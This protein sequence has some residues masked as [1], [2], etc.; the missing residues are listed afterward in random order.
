MKEED[1]RKDYPGKYSVVAQKEGQEGKPA[2]C[3]SITTI[4]RSFRIG[5]MVLIVALLVVVP[6]VV[7]KFKYIY[8][9]L[10]ISTN[11]PL[12]F[13]LANCKLYITEDSTLAADDIY[14]TADVPGKCYVRKIVGRDFDHNE[15]S[16]HEISAHSNIGYTDA[17]VTKMWINP[18]AVLSGLEVACSGTCYI[19]QMGPSLLNLGSGTLAIS[20]DTVEL[21]AV[22]V[23]AGQVQANVLKGNLHIYSLALTKDDGQNHII[24]GEGD[25]VI[26]SLNSVKIAWSNDKDHVCMYAPEMTELGPSKSS[27]QVSRDASSTPSDCSSS[28]FLCKRS[29][30]CSVSTSAPALTL[31]SS[32]G[33]VYAN[34]IDAEGTPVSDS[35]KSVRGW[36]YTRGLEFDDNLNRTLTDYVDGFNGSAK[37]DPLIWVSLGATQSFS[38]AGMVFLLVANTAYLNA[39]PWWISFFSANLLLGNI[40]RIQGNLA[41]GV[42]PFKTLPTTNDLHTIRSLLLTRLTL[43]SGRADAAYA[44]SSSFPPISSVPQSSLGF[45]G[46]EGSTQFYGISFD[47]SQYSL[48][49]YGLAR[50]LSLLLAVIISCILAFIM[51]CL[52]FYILLIVLEKVVA[53]FLQQNSHLRQYTQRIRKEEK[54]R[55]LN[56]RPNH[57]A[58]VNMKDEE[59]G[60]NKSSIIS[61][62]QYML[63]DI[64]VS[65]LKKN[66]T[67]SVDE[68]CDV[69]FAKLNPDDVDDFQPIR[70]KVLR[71]EYEKMCFLKQMSEEDL[72][73]DTNKKKFQA[74][75]FT[76]EK[77][78]KGK[79]GQEVEM[80]LKVRWLRDDE[81]RASP[82][83]INKQSPDASLQKFFRSNCVITTFDADKIEFEEFKE[84]Y[85]KY[86]ADERLPSIVLTRARLHD[87]FSI[88]S[89]TEMPD[90]MVRAET[91]IKYKVDLNQVRQFNEELI[92]MNSAQPKQETLKAI[93][94]NAKSKARQ[95][96]A[97]IYDVIAVGLHL[98]WL[99]ILGC[100][101]VILPL[102]V[103]LEI[104]E[105]SLSDYQYK[106]KYEDFIYA[107]WN[108]P[109][110]LQYLSP[111]SLVCLI[112][113]G[114]YLFM[115]TIELVVYY[116]YMTFP[117]QS[118]KEYMKMQQTTSAK[119]VRIIE[120]G[121][122]CIVISVTIMYLS[123]AIVWSILGAI[124]NPNVYLAY[125]AAA[126]TLVGFILG[127]ITEFS[128]LNS[129]GIQAL[130]DM[131]FSKLQG[132]LDDIMKKILIQAG[133]ATETVSNMLSSEGGIIERAERLARNS[134][135]GK[136]MASVGIDPK[137]AIGMLSGD[138][139]ALIEIGVK[140]GVPK[141]VMK[142]LLGIIKGQKKVI[143]DGL[144]K[145]ANSPQLQINPEVVQLA[146]DIITNNSDLNIP[147]LITNLSKVFFDIMYNQIARS[148]ETDPGTMACLD[149]AKQVFPR[150]IAAFRHF[151]VEEMDT[152]LEQYEDINE[153]LYETVKKKAMLFASPKV[154]VVEEKEQPPPKGP[155]KPVGFM[156]DVDEDDDE[157][158][159]KPPIG[160]IQEH[161]TKVL[162]KTGVFAKLFNERGEPK[163]ALPSYVMKAINVIKL[164]NIEEGGKLQG[165]ALQRVKDSLFYILENFLGADKKVLNMLNLLLASQPEAIMGTSS[166]DGL[167][168]LEEQEKIVTDMGELLNVPP[169]LLRLA[170]KIWTGNYTVNKEF[171]DEI[172]GFLVEKKWVSSSS[173][174]SGECKSIMKFLLPL[175]SVASTHISPS[176]LMEMSNKFS[177][178]SSAAHIVYL[179]G[180]TRLTPKLFD[181]LLTNPLFQAVAQELQIPVSQTLGLIALLRGDFSSPQLSELLDALLHRWGFSMVPSQLIVSILA[182]FLG[183]EEIDIISSVQKL[184][185]LPLEFIL[186]AKELLH[187]GNV[188]DSVFERLGIRTD[189]P[190]VAN[191]IYIPTDD[192][193][194][195]ATW[196]KDIQKLLMAEFMPVKASRPAPAVH[197]KITP[198]EKKSDNVNENPKKKPIK[199]D[200]NKASESKMFSPEEKKAREDAKLLLSINDLTINKE[201]VIGLLTR[202]SMLKD[203]PEDKI[204][205]V[206]NEIVSLLQTLRDI[207]EGSMESQVRSA[208]DKIAKMM[209]I[210]SAPLNAVLS[211]I[212]LKDKQ[213]VLD[214]V[215]LLLSKVM[216]KHEIEEFKNFC[217]L[218]LDKDKVMKNVEESLKTIADKLKIP[219]FLVNFAL[220]PLN[221]DDGKPKFTI[222]EFMLLLDQAG[223]NA[224]AL[225]NAGITFSLP[226]GNP[227]SFDELRFMLSGL[228]M[229]N[230]AIIKQ[231]L[232][233]LGLPER[234]LNL[235]FTV[236]ADNQMDGIAAVFESLYPLLEKYGIPKNAFHTLLEIV[237]IIWYSL[238]STNFQMDQ[239]QSLTQNQRQSQPDTNI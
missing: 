19:A 130:Q 27:C 170:W 32:L 239:H 88:E 177:L 218:I 7:F 101:V 41:P 192:P 117:T 202:T 138:E 224:T 40:Y 152:F 196:L 22:R 71:A 61:I 160:K 229:G 172:S 28:Y 2:S 77:P 235:A 178:E 46:I 102:F 98:A 5:V 51:G 34:V 112:I 31:S 26:Q 62:S 16:T 49:E 64:L 75:G 42:C 151:S 179:F 44:Y 181:S 200:E 68:F 144:Q 91:N 9:K 182:I 35:F 156:G 24:T 221:S 169:T 158:P 225:K 154:V 21:M 187:P 212:T 137:D 1:S 39:Y 65:E 55:T 43:F 93:A 209:N 83:D 18:Q 155:P 174:E 165:M 90:Y 38:T 14:L 52:M 48:K 199:H 176:S 189:D 36:S 105:Y 125:G 159:N 76:F 12:K 223:F 210:Q 145:F 232:Q 67:S 15:G 211:L 184:N 78:A 109:E 84:R 146:I 107:P 139:E 186:V 238:N 207:K 149:I 190:N 25:V 203:I 191:R 175:F 237:R 111:V 185:L 201:L 3:M 161:P 60:A 85:E 180:N 89:I 99:L 153:Y 157:L 141:D 116:R 113:A 194:L 195:W 173:L 86:C 128:K 37:A 10:H 110:K 127:K 222:E 100:I 166:K 106:L 206:S 30:T 132:F 66:F 96:R 87:M 215:E 57:V 80:L 213:S 205:A 167:I 129:M 140:Q 143:V 150:L 135:I 121:Y 119:I 104:S 11:K 126:A 53:H 23:A 115:G 69:L 193:G 73:S 47:G 231:L 142:L 217:T 72:M 103:E 183:T 188:S 74:K 54:V 204:D 63:I 17:C 168:T 131:L 6:V 214:A 227:L 148:I 134:P 219:K 220:S 198:E 82:A 120:W 236:A 79:K 108:I 124:L 20:G 228:V 50:T 122:I 70:V 33:N 56:A 92:E 118:L 95:F 226:N 216:S 234:I 45:R 136:A 81:P 163:I 230:S 94:N 58:D 97:F 29:D 162:A 197:K 164:V 114:I 8:K 133:F 59:E 171:I 208:V 233:H 13:A 123:L 147:I 4:R